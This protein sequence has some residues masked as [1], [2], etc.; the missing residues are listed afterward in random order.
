MLFYFFF[1]FL[2]KKFICK[3][4]IMWKLGFKNDPVEKFSLEVF[5]LSHIYFKKK[6]KGQVIYM[7][8][9]F[10]VDDPQLCN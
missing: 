7:A 4:Q 3:S 9:W 8:G 6:K 2:R 5:R 1:F 10:D